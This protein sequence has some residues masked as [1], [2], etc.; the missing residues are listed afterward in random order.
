MPIDNCVAVSLLNDDSCIFCK[1]VQKQSPGN[2]VYEDETVMAFLDI[3]PINEG[4][5]LVIPKEHHKDIFEIPS[6]LLAYLHSISKRI[7]IAVKETTKADGISIFQQNGKAADQEIP[8]LHIHIVPRY[9]GQRL[10]RFS[11]RS[12]VN[13]EKLQQVAMNIRRHM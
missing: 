11:E 7:A 13:R 2:I 9:E 12:N 1:I 10:G 8:H 5:T 6:E 3:N 4:H